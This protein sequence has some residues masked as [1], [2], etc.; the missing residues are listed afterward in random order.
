M[1]VKKSRFNKKIYKS[2]KV[3]TIFKMNS[4]IHL[5]EQSYILRR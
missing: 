1:N 4:N 3:F 2:Q 5:Q